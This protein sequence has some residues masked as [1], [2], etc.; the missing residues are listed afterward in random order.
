MPKLSYTADICMRA[1]SEGN[2]YI[3]ILAGTAQAVLFSEV[4]RFVASE[5]HLRAEAAA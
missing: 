1:Q 4:Y 2:I 3:Y 5:T